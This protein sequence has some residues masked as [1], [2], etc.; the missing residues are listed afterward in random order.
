[1]KH[2]CVFTV[3][4]KAEEKA[5]EKEAKG[6]LFEADIVLTKQ[7][8]QD[9]DTSINAGT[10]EIHIDTNKFADKRKGVRNRKNLWPSR[11]VPYEISPGFG[12]KK[13]SFIVC[14]VFFELIALGILTTF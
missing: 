3:I 1:M 6:K 10:G 8:I 4:T 13:P 5:I 14:M 7:D 11:T 12:K 2:V 9:V